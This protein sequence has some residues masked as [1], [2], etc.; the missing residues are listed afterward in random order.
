MPEKEPQNLAF[1]RTAAFFIWWIICYKLKGQIKGVKSNFIFAS[2]IAHNEVGKAIFVDFL[3]KAF[4]AG[5]FIAAPEPYVVGKGVEN[6]QA[7][8][9]YQKK[10]TSAGKVVVSL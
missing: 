6:I 10:G 4:E 9:E 2:S 8:F 7:A 3:P 1:L 5:T